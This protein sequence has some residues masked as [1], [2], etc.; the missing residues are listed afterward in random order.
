MAYNEQRMNSKGGWHGQARLHASVSVFACDARSLRIRS[1]S[2][3]LGH[4]TLRSAFTL[5]ELLVVVSII[6]LLLSTLLP[7]LRHAREQARTAVCGSNI[8][9]LALANSL[10]ANDNRHCYC[11]GAVDFMATNL[12][13]WHGTRDGKTHAFDGRSGPLA[14]YLGPEGDIRTC[15]SIRIDLPEDDP[16]RFEKNC[17]GYGYNLAFVG[18]RLEKVASGSYRVETDR[19]GAQTDRIRRPAQTVM[20]TDSAFLDGDFIEYS[21]AEP[22]FWP[23]F[24]GRPNPTIHFRHAKKTNVAWCDGHVDWQ[25]RTFTYWATGLYQGDPD[26]HDLGWFGG[27]DDNSLFDLR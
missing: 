19:V 23:L 6:A 7:S 10:Y 25:R 21:F 4:A 1:S 27:T 15:P 8:R 14:P 24:G 2:D 5:V 12:H 13:R 18:R 26:R 9:Q 3:T 11:P 16:R 22:R 20:F 17:G